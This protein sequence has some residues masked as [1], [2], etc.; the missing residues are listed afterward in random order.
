M[1]ASAQLLVGNGLDGLHIHFDVRR[2]SRD[3]GRDLGSMPEPGTVLQGACARSPPLRLVVD[4][5]AVAM[6]HG[7]RVA[8]P[9]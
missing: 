8:L 7:A 1:P 2:K 6:E 3:F 5:V 4:E 9:A